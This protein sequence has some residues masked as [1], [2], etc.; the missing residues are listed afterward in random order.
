M[1]ETSDSIVWK[2]KLF[3]TLRGKCPYSEFF[4]S[5]I[6]RIWTEY[7][8]NIQFKCEKIRTGKTPNTNTFYAV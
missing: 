1:Q 8:E 7:G 6:T 2:F 4:W 3:I 5:V